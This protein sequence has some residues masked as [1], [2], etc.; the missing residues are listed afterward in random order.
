MT[1]IK[2]KAYQHISKSNFYHT[3]YDAGGMTGYGMAVEDSL[4]ES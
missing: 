4:R 1:I 2:E 3:Q